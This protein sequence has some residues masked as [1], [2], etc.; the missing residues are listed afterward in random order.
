MTKE[1]YSAFLKHLVY[2]VKADNKIDLFE[3]LV[4]SLLLQYLKP[5][6]EKVKPVQ[7]K[8]KQLKT[9]DNECRVLI[10]HLTYCGSDGNADSVGLN[11][12]FDQGFNALGLGD[13][14]LLAQPDLSLKDLNAAIDRF[15]RLYPLIKPR[16]LKACAECIQADN[17]VTQEEYELLRVIAALIDCPMPGME[18]NE[19]TD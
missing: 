1:E 9:L 16:F 19:I 5:N 17:V 12:V 18:I 8:Y 15:A 14:S 4:Y 13:S 7:A 10:S 6:F 3:W 2:F 11:Q